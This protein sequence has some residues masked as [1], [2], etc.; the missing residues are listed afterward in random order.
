MEEN[1]LEKIVVIGGSAGSLDVLLQVLPLLDKTLGMPLIVVLHRKTSFDSTLRDLFATRTAL[2]VQEAEEKET[3]MPGQIYIAPADYHLLIERDRSVSFDFSEKV[4]YSRPSIDV[5][6]E[7]AADVYGTG[8]A[9]I[10]LSG[11]NS[12]GASGLKTIRLRGGKTA[13]QDPSSAEIDY[14]PKQAIA[15]HAA[16]HILPVNEIAHFINGL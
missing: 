2:A 7:S 12:D 1:S 10:L 3:L 5:T 14:M 4:H 9:G 6:F 11:A 13:V 8:A 16:E 15:I